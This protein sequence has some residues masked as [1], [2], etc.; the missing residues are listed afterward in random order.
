M[1]P[2]PIDSVPSARLSPQ[3]LALALLAFAVT[4]AGAAADDPA[5][6]YAAHV[7]P[8]MTQYCLTC[9]SQKAKK[10]DLDLERFTSLD[11]VR[12]DLR[13]W[14]D[15]L[16]KLDG[17]EMPPKKATQPTLEEHQRLASW[18]REFLTA[19]ARAR[20]GDPGRVIVRRLSNA[21][22]DYTVRDLTGMD[23]R[24][25]RDFPADGAAG[26]GFTNAGDALVMSP[27]LL[28]KYLNAA[29]GVAAH[30]V[31][32]P[33]GFRFSPSAERRDWTDE[34][35]ADLRKA[36]RQDDRGRD[37]GRLDFTPYLA[38]TLAYRDNL[39]SGKMT[40]DAV[41]VKEQLSPKYLQVLWQTLTDPQPSFPLDEIRA[42]WRQA[43]PKDVDAAAS[44]IRTW[45]TLLW[46]F[47]KV[48]S[49]MNPVRQDAS[50]PPF[51]ESQ[52]I[53]FKPPKP[54]AGKSEVVLYLTARDL[55]GRADAQVVW[56]RPRLEGGKQ[57]PLLLRDVADSGL[58]KSRFG[59]DAAGKPI[60]EASLAAVAPSVVEVRLPAV[61]LQDRE[62][63][64][65]GRSTRIVRT[66]WC[67][68]RCGPTPPI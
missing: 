29:K 65:E 30:A 16:D 56:R 61:A 32:L 38:A 10:G 48:G 44:E 68:S 3:V 27:T 45:Q 14:R 12:K 46:K 64:V 60:E 20:A 51:V 25:T 15:V 37:D 40:I 28:T 63:A 36:Y 1:T 11:E 23:L 17:G 31:L 54:P 55:T 43:D 8:L 6:E 39:T 21:E 18:V 59:H 9:H 22:Y 52:L 67:S 19:E 66:G 42:R 41:A 35:L 58:D 57:S 24:P 47:N 2:S 34:A 5:R 50:N 33:N 4:P 26:E 13:P 7:R 53:R 62:F 49:Y